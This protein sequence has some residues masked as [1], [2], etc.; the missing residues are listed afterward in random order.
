MNRIARLVLFIIFISAMMG[1]LS[2][3]RFS[4][5]LSSRTRVLGAG[6]DNSLVGLGRDLFFNE[7][8]NGNGRTCG[9]CHTVDDS[10]GLTPATIA[11][12]PQTDPLFIAETNPNLTTLEHPPLMRGPRGLILEN[13]DGFANPPVFRGS[14]HLQNIALTAPYGL[15]G[16]I[17]DLRAF[18]VGAV[19]QHFPKTM[20]RV[21]G[22]DFRLPTAFEQQ[23]MEAFMQSIFFP[24]DGNFALERFV[25]T[26]QQRRGSDLFFGTAKCSQCHNG[27]VLATASPSLGGGNQTFNTGVVNLLINIVPDPNNPGG[28]P[29]PQEAGG[30]R[31]F[32][33]PPLMGVR[34]TAPFFHDSS[35]ATLREA[36]AFYD[37]AQFN[38]SP[39][40]AIVGP[41]GLPAANIDDIT[42]FLDSMR[43]YSFSVNPG[44]VSFGS[45]DVTASEIATTVAVT[46]NGNSPLSFTRIGLGG[47]P[48]DNQFKIV[49]LTT[50]PLAPGE[51]RLITIA[52]DPTT[53]GRK[54]ASLEFI[55]NAGDIG[56]PLVGVGTNG[57]VTFTDVPADH[58]AFRFIEAV[59]RRGITDGC[60]SSPMSFCPNASLTRA[61]V[62]ILLLRAMGRRDIPARGIFGD[63][64]STSFGAGFIE[65]MAELGI[66]QGC[67]GGNFCPDNQVTRGD[68]A[69]FIIKAIGQTPAT[70][71]GVFTDV[72]ASDPQAPFIERMAQ[73]G[74]TSGCG[75]GN[76]CPGAPVT[77][78]QAA[79]FIARAFHL[80]L[81]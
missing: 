1:L 62:A 45:R 38:Q 36:V 25:S 15:S 10:F 33:T 37:G 51:S 34:N 55:T 75:G 43:D 2:L 29:L 80:P 13:I 39:A 49:G 69:V 61:Q 3:D 67:G 56:M 21:E 47:G 65:K 14:P 58:F 44:M 41:I 60:S 30:L 11:S 35:V 79:V 23:A 7:T 4:S 76:F 46:N 81:P 16:E 68:I 28:G 73:L 5:V 22:V 42:S 52:F 78:A 27:V 12:L 32:S 17:P 20:N 9:T 26:A 74:I 50:A 59:F 70:A 72:P 66:M 57:N 77:R 31:Q 63:V 19:K 71:T 8:F 40:A 53:A 64:T 54:G 48:Q 18:A 24:A 6:A